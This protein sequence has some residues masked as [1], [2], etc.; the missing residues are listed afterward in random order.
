MKVFIQS[1]I[2]V[3]LFSFFISCDSA[4]TKLKTMED[5]IPENASL[6]LRINDFEVLKIGKGEL[7]VV[8]WPSDRR[9]TG[10][11]DAIW[12]GKLFFKYKPKLIIGH[13]VG[14]NIP[15][16]VSKL[17]SFGKTKTFVYYHTLSSQI[18]LD[19]TRSFIFQKLLYFRK[20]IPEI[21]DV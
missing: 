7:T 6:V 5:F 13:F 10:L 3:L 16:I 8:S 2:V 17:I 20:K 18:K 15:S 12:F 4:P 19:S 11:I 1:T 21:P 9:P 14:S